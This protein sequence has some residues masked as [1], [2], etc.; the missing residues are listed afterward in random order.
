MLRYRRVTEF[1]HPRSLLRSSPRTT[2]VATTFPVVVPLGRAV[3]LGRNWPRPPTSEPLSAFLR[4]TG[5]TR[6]AP[7]ALVV[8]GVHRPVRE[9]HRQAPRESGPAPA[10]PPPMVGMWVKVSEEDDERDDA[11]RR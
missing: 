9:G 8:V 6:L 2:S 4:R 7:T 11:T 10:E 3:D 1:S 5:S